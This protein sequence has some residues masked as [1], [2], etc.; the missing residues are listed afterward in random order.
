MKKLIVILLL[1]PVF[2]IAQDY[3]KYYSGINKA[4][5]AI[6][7]DS[8]SKGISHYFQTFEKFNFIFARDCYNAIELSALAKDSVKL[9]Y[10]IRRGIKHGLS[11][12]QIL[13]MKN[14][15]EFSNS[16]FMSQIENEKESLE[17]IY[18]NSIDLELRKEIIEMFKQDQLKRE[19][20]GGAFLFKRKRIGREWE[21]L[22]AIQVERLIEITEKFG[23]PG[24][25]LIGIDTKIMHAKIN[26]N[27]IAAGMPII[28]FIHHYSQPNESYNYILKNEIERGNLYNEHYAIISDFQHTFGKGK[29]GP[30]ACYSERFNPKVPRDKIDLNRL[31]IGLLSLS[32]TDKLQ[33]RNYITPFWRRLR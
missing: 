21:A 12:N 9:D 16:D 20:Y 7:Q 17:K 24:E 31:K 30:I 11:F 23:F 27:D 10:F 18:T 28:I 22:N 32:N 5:M 29:F 14:I 3:T 8:L 15:P 2:S 13:K 33:S 6:G 25:K 4:K 19:E 26:D 1:I